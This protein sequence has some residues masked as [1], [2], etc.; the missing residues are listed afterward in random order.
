[1]LHA[2]GLI[3]PGE[4]FLHKSIIGT[5][6]TGEVI[7]TLMVGGKP[8]IRPAITGGAWITG[9]HQYVLD[10]SD[11]LPTGYTLNDLWKQRA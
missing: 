10:D 2:R 4:K 11:P 3:S 5:E 6:Y 8:G 7:E 9:F 1:V